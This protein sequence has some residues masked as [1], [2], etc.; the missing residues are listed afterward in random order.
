M[1]TH[2]SAKVARWIASLMM[3]LGFAAP[4][5]RALT[6]NLTY[7]SSTVGAPTNFFTGFQ[8]A[9]DFY[10]ATYDDPITI[11]LQVGWGK[12]NGQNLNPG[13]VGQSSTSQ[14]TY[15]FSQVRAALVSD[16]K[17]ADDFTA[18]SNLPVVD[19]TGGASFPMSTAEAKA[20]GLLS[21]NATGLDGYVGFSSTASYTFDPNNRA[22]SG[23]YDFVGLASHE[24]TEIM[25]RYGLGQN[26]ASSGRYSPIDLFRYTSPG[27]LDLVPENGDYF[28]ID[29]GKTVINTF[30]GTGG[31]DLSDWAGGT[32]DSY[33]AFLTAGKTNVISA[34]DLTEMDVIGFDR[35]VPPPL[36]MIK[37][38]G[39]GNLIISWSTLSTRFI[40]QTNSNLA[41]TNW[42]SAS[43]PI[44]TNSG[45]NFS[46]TVPLPVTGEL[47]F[48]LEK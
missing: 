26:G 27:V 10:E 12:I 47:F 36:L 11:N 2:F 43:Y 40:I 46:V 23:K 37:P 13:D 7:D 17:S 42:S 8:A 41:A 31:G 4:H 15:T 33:N 21:G 1:R 16:A 48:R 44:S 3:L 9:V 6:F 14:H 30:N 20:L 34:G 18:I 25:G 35:V 22:V 28:S 39:P 24:I 5:S 32:V 38:N 29:G 19:P 45:T